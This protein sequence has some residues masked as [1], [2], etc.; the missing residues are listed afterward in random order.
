M[1]SKSLKILVVLFLIGA[2]F[3]ACKRDSSGRYT[4]LPNVTGTA[5]E[6]LIILDKSLWEESIGKTITEIIKFDY[7]MV[8]QK[9]PM[10]DLVWVPTLSFSDIFKTHRNIIV[11][12]AGNEYTKAEIIAQR[13]IWATPQMV[14]NIVGPTY[15]AIERMLYSDRD[16]L[17]QIFELAERERVIANATKF[18]EKGLGQLIEKKFG[19]TMTFPKGYKLNKD[20]TDFVW[21][22]YE[23]PNTSQGIFIYSYPYE[24]KNT[25]TT[26]FLVEKRNSFLNALVPG[27]TAGSYMTTFNEILPIFNQFNYKNRHYG[28]LRGLWDVHAHPMGGPFISLTTINQN[29]NLVI[30]VEGYVYAPRF[31]KRNYLRQVE[32]LLYTLS[33]KE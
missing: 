32:A 17:I 24:D 30:T 33:V 2:T 13:D 28:Q 20:T 11:V 25:F 21:I 23:T 1:L 16:K 7:P 10:F 15:P 31:K 9:E 19:A 22:S 27:P 3:T 4:S 8:P 12:K 6:L 14:V 5:G 18:E 29:R 26:Q